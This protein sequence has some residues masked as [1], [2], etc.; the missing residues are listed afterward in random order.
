MMTLSFGKNVMP[1][2]QNIIAV[3]A[4]FAG[5]AAA[6]GQDYAAEKEWNIRPTL[7]IGAGMLN[8]QGDLIGGRGYFNPFQNKLALHV[9][10]SQP[11]NNFIDLNF[12]MMYGKLGAD[13]RTLVRNLNFES[14]VTTGGVYLTYNFDHLL[15]EH[16]TLEPYVSLG[17]EA[18]EF[19][20][21]TDLID[22]YGNIYYYWSDGTIRNMPETDDNVE[23]AIEITR[24]YVYETDI[25]ERNADGFGDYTE[26]S[27]AIPF[28]GGFNFLINSKVTFT[29]GMEYHWTFTDYIDG[30]TT[31]SRG[32]RAGNKQT[33]RFVHTFMRLGY[34][35]TPVPIEESP[36]FSGGDNS[37]S[38]Q[39][40]IVDFLDDCPF[41]KTGMQVD[42]KG[43]PLDSDNDGVADFH[44]K[45]LNSPQ[46]S[47]VD[48]NGIALTDRD[49]ERMYL[50]YIDGTGKYAQY[51]NTSYSM[52]SAVRKTKRKKTEFSVKIGEFE[53]GVNDSLANTLL[54]MP[55]V[56]SRQTADGKIIIEMGSFENLPDAIQRRID[57][58]AEGIATQDVMQKAVDGQ[59]SRVTNIEQNVI[60]QKNI[61]MTVEEAIAKNRVLPPPQ[62]LILNR[63]QYTLDRPIDPRSVAKVDDVSFGEKIVYR[64]QI[65]AF[66]NKLSDDVF[67][68]ISDL[69]VVTMEDGLT[70]YY[71]GSF[72]AY[73]Q[74]AARKIDMIE[75]GFS[76]SYVVP[77]KGG[78]R[79]DLEDAGA[80]PAENVVPL[81]SGKPAN[82][83]KVKF[84]IQI[85]AYAGDIPTDVLDK[86]MGLG[87]IDQRDGENG[88]IRYF[89]GD[90]NTY[91]EAQAFK[92]QLIS[93]GFKDSFVAAEF[94]GRIISATEG[95]ELLK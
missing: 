13:E 95:I 59:T 21:K 54:S 76:G 34:D 24:D 17:F 69:L 88:L 33:D 10:A 78:K 51:A 52:E 3:A 73:E 48:S 68:D 53:E 27:F 64:V 93:Q 20:S 40:G 43:C 57:L 46:G 92:N 6:H 81:T 16:R 26:R 90:F 65:G 91:E 47:V 56:T 14:R 87:K 2:L 60:A 80:T 83:G 71:S 89:A 82:Y 30:I 39:D 11:L 45:E 15:N 63:D 38:D 50:E 1:V 29:M 72:T 58:E 22:S 74:A 84:K 41:T 25:R 4:L 66:A 70:R 44:D 32:L 85:G 49:F 7:S 18:F 86:M 35:L 23:S 36:D 19:L 12:F 61:G 28:G 31:E 8:Y 79:V 5:I 55:D 67:A 62:K 75:R 77:F 9:N 42:G 94:N 37:D